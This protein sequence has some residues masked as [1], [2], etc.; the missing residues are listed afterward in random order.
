VYECR[1]KFRIRIGPMTYADFERL[2]PGGDSL[3]RLRAWL[4]NYVGDELEWEAQLVLKKEEVPS[5]QLGTLGRL[6]W[7]TWLKSRPFSRD[8]EDL[9]LR[10]VKA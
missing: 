8:A 4:K 6:G 9:I 7:S 1:Q 2:L 3:D 5:A 10:P